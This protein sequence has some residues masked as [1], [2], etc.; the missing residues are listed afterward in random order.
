VDVFGRQFVRS[1]LQL[2][3]RSK[4]SVYPVPQH[5]ASWVE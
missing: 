5:L 4:R 3:K 2:P 1:H